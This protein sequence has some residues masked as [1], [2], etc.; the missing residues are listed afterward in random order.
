[1]KN[2][3]DKV[4]LVTGA[5]MGMG[6]SLSDLLLTEGC[7]LALVDVNQ[8]ELGKTGAALS[9]KGA[10]R[11]YV[12]DI[13]DRQAV[14]ELVTRVKADLGPVSLLV[15]NAGIMKAGELLN[16]ED[17]LIEKML[18]VNLASMF[19]MCKAFLPDMIAQQEGHVVNF[20]SAGGILAIPNLSAYCASKFGV[21][22]FSDALRQEMKKNQWKVGV[23]C[24]CP[25]TVGTGMF[26]GAQMVAGTRLLQTEQVTKKVLAGI[27]KNRAMVCVPNIS[28]NF[29]TP[30]M[31]LLLPVTVMD[32]LNQL[33][34]MWHAND[35]TRGRESS[36]SE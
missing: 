3:R 19:W 12:C 5:A 8:A 27:R 13:A 25:N 14:Y 15:N 11:T 28:V 36:G 4:A 6:R 17:G 9:Q 34:G 31:K 30:L 22:G 33:L 26:E 32:R 21:V 7:R 35:A 1:M 18:Q 20:A 2:L 29:V 10:C 16:L 23:S 24:V